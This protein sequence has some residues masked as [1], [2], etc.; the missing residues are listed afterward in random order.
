MTIFLVNGQARLAWLLK[1][2]RRASYYLH[3]LSCEFSYSYGRRG[4]NSF[5]LAGESPASDQVAAK[6]LQTQP[7]KNLRSENTSP[8][9]SARGPP[10]KPHTFPPSFT[11]AFLY[12]S[13]G[14][15]PKSTIQFPLC[16]CGRWQMHGG[17]LVFPRQAGHLLWLMLGCGKKMSWEG[18][19]M[20]GLQTGRGY[21]N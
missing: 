13:D 20:E 14:C 11:R 3:F 17:H 10:S 19:T 21:T 8:V 12:C 16:L 4:K 6:S 9:S 15:I 7:W 1:K 5:A 18:I 2:G